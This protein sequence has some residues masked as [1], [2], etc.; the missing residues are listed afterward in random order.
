M[1]TNNTEKSTQVNK[2]MGKMLVDQKS[3]KY[4]R[5]SNIREDNILHSWQF[6]L[7]KGVMITEKLL[8]RKS[9]ISTSDSIQNKFQ[10]DYI[11]NI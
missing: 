2:Y 4:V 9:W 1:N 10:M 3:L 7:K 5:E 6:Y 8:E 11:Y